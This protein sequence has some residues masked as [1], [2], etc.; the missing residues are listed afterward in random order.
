MLFALKPMVSLSNYFLLDRRNFHQNVPSQ[1]EH[2][3]KISSKNFLQCAERCVIVEVGL[4]RVVRS[5]NPGC[6]ASN[7]NSALLLL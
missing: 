2:L 7:N 4:S 5:T 6:A 3:E 1:M